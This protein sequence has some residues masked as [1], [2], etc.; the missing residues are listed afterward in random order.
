[1]C[2]G[3]TGTSILPKQGIW[4]QPFPS[5]PCLSCTLLLLLMK[6]IYYLFKNSR[7]AELE[8]FQAGWNS[9]YSPQDRKILQAVTFTSW[10]HHWRPPCHRRC[11]YLHTIT[12]EHSKKGG[13]GYKQRIISFMGSIGQVEELAWC[14]QQQVLRA[15]F[16]IQ[17]DLHVSGTNNNKQYQSLQ[18]FF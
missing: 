13:N 9:N 2:Q 6:L 12:L 18:I 11:A 5:V 16:V 7:K 8:M 10:L 1:M 15:F 3:M 14:S 4:V 17:K